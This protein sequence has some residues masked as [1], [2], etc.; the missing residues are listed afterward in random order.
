MTN[1]NDPVTPSVV[2][3]PQYNEYGV[4]YSNTYSMPNGLTKR[5][6]FAGL[7]MQ[8]LL[9]DGQIR[10][11]IAIAQNAVRMANYLINELN[12]TNE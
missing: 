8:G 10:D 5:E 4:Q 9:A 3:D 7:A 1:G 12:K 2:T 6:Y 11:K